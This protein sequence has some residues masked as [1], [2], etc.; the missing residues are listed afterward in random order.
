MLINRPFYENLKKLES[1]DLFDAFK[2]MP[3]PAVHHAHLTGCVSVDYLVEL[4]Y[5][6]KVYYNAE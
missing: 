4:T 3:K 5:H 2:K 6:K 1:C